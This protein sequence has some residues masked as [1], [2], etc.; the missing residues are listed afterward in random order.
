MASLKAM[1]HS[2]QVVKAAARL[3]VPLPSTKEEDEAYGTLDAYIDDVLG[4]PDSKRPKEWRQR[5][6]ILDSEAALGGQLPDII[7]GD[8]RRGPALDPS[9]RRDSTRET[10]LAQVSETNVSVPDSG[11]PS[12]TGRPSTAGGTSHG[13]G[14]TAPYLG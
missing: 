11:R 14:A 2:E 12:L 10:Q 13:V 5:A 4:V 6:S 9:A 7:F 1:G 3:G 8:G